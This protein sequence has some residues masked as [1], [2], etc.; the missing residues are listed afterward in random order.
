MKKNIIVLL[1]VFCL[2]MEKNTY[3]QVYKV[4]TNS[5]KNSFGDITSKWSFGP[6]LGAGIFSRR[7]GGF[8]E[9]KLNDNIGIQ[10]GI[11]YFKDIYLAVD[12]IN[13]DY[14]Y[15][16]MQNIAVPVT[17]RM[18]PG[19]NINFCFLVGI[20]INYLIEGNN[21]AISRERLEQ[22]NA[23]NNSNVFIISKQEMKKFK[24]DFMGGFDYEFN[25]GLILG[26]I[27]TKGLFDIIEGKKSF[28]DWTLQITSGYNMAKFF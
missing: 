24:L 3:A 4:K 17:L 25:F 26:I 10:T 18:Y 8:V 2:L 1:S 11:I 28:G 12:S 14:A 7:A 27:Y 21:V 23:R 6:Q 16:K 20:M 5:Y 13:K 22:F 9:H 19:N 15:F